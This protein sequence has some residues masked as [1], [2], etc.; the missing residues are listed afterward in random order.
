MPT[1]KDTVKSKIKPGRILHLYC[2]F[3]KPPKNKFLVVISE[4]PLRLFIVNSD[5][6]KFK[7]ANQEILNC[8]IEILKSNYSFLSKPIS[9]I[10]CSAMIISFKY[11]DVVKELVK[12]T[13]NIK[14]NLTNDTKGLIRIAVSNSGLYSLINKN[15]VTAHLS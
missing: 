2:D 9:F 1:V 4:N 14:C 11:E 8:Q 3:T 13:N 7:S 15:L 10:D 6:N 12:D 5:I